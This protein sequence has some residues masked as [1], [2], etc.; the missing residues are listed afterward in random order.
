M[1]PR[2]LSLFAP[3][4]AE[5]EAASLNPRPSGPE[6]NFHACPWPDC[7]RTVPNELWGCRPHWYALP[8]PIRQRIWSSYRRGQENDGKI[9]RQYLDA[10]LEAQRW[11]AE[12]LAAA[13]GRIDS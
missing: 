10:I 7:G 11:I 12:F 13:E 9:S 5:V 3:S 8:K 4:P 1:R 2:Q 6:R